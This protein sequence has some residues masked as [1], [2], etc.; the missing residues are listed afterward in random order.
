MRAASPDI[1]SRA[2]DEAPGCDRQDLARATFFD[3]GRHSEALALR[4]ADAL[5]TGRPEAA[6]MFADRRCRLCAPTAYDLMLRAIASRLMNETAYAE[7]DL[8]KAFEIDPTHDLVIANA[9]AWGAPELKPIAAAS[10]I[11]GESQDR[12]SLRLAMQVLEQAATPIVSRMRV[13]EGMHEGWVAWRGGGALTLVIRRGGMG[14]S[15]DLQPDA[16]HPLACRAWSAVQIAIEIESPRLETV[17]FRLDGEHPLTICLARDR[18]EARFP[19]RKRGSR[20]S[21]SE[22]PDHVEVIVP[23]YGDYAATRVCLDALEAEGSRIAKHITVIDDCSPDADIR[24]LVE[25]GA[26]RGMFTLVRNEENLG[27]ARSVNRALAR[28]VQSDVLLLNADTI[29]PRESIDRLA[30]AAYSEPGVATVTPLSN[31]GE[32]TSFPKPNV[33]NALPTKEELFALDEIATATNGRGIIDLPSGVGFCLFITRECLEEVGLLSEAYSRGYFEDVDYCL[34]AREIGFRN[35]CATGVYVGHAGTRSFEN[36]KRRLVVHNL[37]LLKERFPDCERDCSTFVQADPLKSAR[38]KLEERL[39]P[40]GTVVLLLASVASGRALALER[41][42]QIEGQGDDL[43]CIYCEVGDRNDRMT[44][45]SVRGSAPQ[46]LTFALNEGADLARLH[47]YL[48]HAQPQAVEVIAP[49]ALPDPALRLARALQV[50]MRIAFGDL[51]WLCDRDFVLVKSCPRADR[52][53]E[54]HACVGSARPT[55][56]PSERGHA[57]DRRRTNA[58]MVKAESIAP[59]D[60]MAAAFC[61]AYLKST[62]LLVS[63]PTHA[64][65]ADTF[66]LK[67]AAAI[68]GVLNPETAEETDRQILAIERLLDEKRVEV[69]VVV[70][71][72]CLNDLDL[73]SKRRIFV[74]GVIAEDEY[75]R[76]L[77]QY[78]I[79]HLFSPYRTRHF[80]LVD[81]LSAAIGLPKGYFDWSFGALERETGD[82]ALDPRICFE[83][84]ARQIGAWITDR[85][86]D[87]GDSASPLIIVSEHRRVDADQPSD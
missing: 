42:R 60:R 3:P 23:V 47:A 61:A 45:K 29:L 11:H 82:L 86:I 16:S 44:L 68:L 31:N 76:V 46:S 75:A 22:I 37:A 87:V 54:C 51:D 8:A 52:P 36:E 10:F 1:G 15:F 80:G 35:V 43:H 38:A 50:P 27:F 9:L 55:A 83:S 6:F 24:T 66:K 12:N 21:R 5:K 32:Y 19:L 18:S 67:P 58:L 2:L 85:P 48:V 39:V 25:D 17:T 53:G 63:A 33:R 40:E 71:G 79:T 84:A 81:R 30:L 73:M 56:R 62:T 74:T 69:S 77:R 59:M 57:D 13:R 4:Y 34:R 20:R 26:A 28:V 41:A 65:T 64:G 70:L 7:A 14:E 78:R 72:R 49:Y